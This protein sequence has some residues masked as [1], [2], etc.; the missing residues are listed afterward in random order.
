MYLKNIKIIAIDC[1][2]V[3]TNGLYTID[4]RGIISKSFHTKDFYA[5]EQI[6]LFGI[7]ILILTQ[8]YDRVILKRISRICKYYYLKELSGGNKNYY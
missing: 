8:C 5:I 6:M 1:D 2:G 4:E 7:K 3:L